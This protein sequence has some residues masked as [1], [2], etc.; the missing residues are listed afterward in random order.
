MQ[1]S[2][3]VISLSCS[4][5][6]L[7]NT[8]LARFQALPFASVS[9]SVLTKSC[10]E[11]DIS[12]TFPLLDLLFAFCILKNKKQTSKQNLARGFFPSKTSCCVP[13]PPAEMFCCFPLGCPHLC[14][15]PAGR[16]ALGS[17]RWVSMEVSTSGQYGGQYGG[18][19]RGPQGLLQGL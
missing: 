18:H 15:P 19:Y 1:C 17:V 5:M 3:Q 12:Q 10:L 11:G 9:P 6:L 2:T 7:S 14:P 8:Q 4:H 13:G 16:A